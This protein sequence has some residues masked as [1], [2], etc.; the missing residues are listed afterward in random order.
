MVVRTKTIIMKIYSPIYVKIL[1]VVRK[2]WALLGFLKVLC[3]VS[4]LLPG[5][6]FTLLSPDQDKV[7]K[8][9]ESL[10]GPGFRQGVKR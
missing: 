2:T 6:N 5:R 3:S 10:A 7:R 9:P 1:V 4:E 8:F